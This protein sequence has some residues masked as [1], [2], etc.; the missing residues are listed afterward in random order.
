MM[1][2][3]TVPRMKAKGVDVDDSLIDI[4]PGIVKIQERMGQKA[5]RMAGTFVT[6]GVTKAACRS[7]L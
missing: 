4:D 5:R 1:D 6:Q 2:H 7:C 3:Y